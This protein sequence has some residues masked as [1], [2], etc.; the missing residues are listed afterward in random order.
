MTLHS[1]INFLLF[2]GVWFLALLFEGQA[3]PA[4]VCIIALMLYLS[5][6]RKL[7]VFVLIIGLLIALCFEFIMVQFGL[8]EFKAAPYP[9]WF[10]LLWSALLLTINTS[11]QFLTRLPWYLSVVVCTI[12]APASYWAG[13]RFEVIS[14]VNP[15]LFRYH[16]LLKLENKSNEKRYHCFSLVP[17][18]GHHWLYPLT[19]YHYLM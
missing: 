12:F 10:M 19:Y 7:D 15:L 11:M 17:H 2:Q 16:P 18:L 1:V 9:V 3:I 14:I 6:Q 5:K 4:I 8:L 13:A